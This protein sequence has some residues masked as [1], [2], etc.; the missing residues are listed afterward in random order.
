MKDTPYF[1]I[2]QIAE[3]YGLSRQAVYKWV[4]SGKLGKPCIHPIDGSRYWL[5]S[6]LPP[7]VERAAPPMGDPLPEGNWE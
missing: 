7:L 3:R 2:T 1:K 5:E 6:D 4:R